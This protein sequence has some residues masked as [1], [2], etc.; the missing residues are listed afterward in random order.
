MALVAALLIAGLTA[1]CA[2]APGDGPERLRLRSGG[3]PRQAL[4]LPARSPGPAPVVLAFHGLGDSGEGFRWGLG[5][6]PALSGATVVLPDALPCFDTGGAP[7]WPAEAGA[8]NLATELAFVE[9]LVHRVAQRFPVDRDRVYALGYSNGA[10]WTVRLVLSRPDLVRGAIVVAGFDPTRAFARDRNGFL[11]LP[12][13]PVGPSGAEAPADRPPL[14]L[15]HGGVDEVVP[16]R[17]GREL[18]ERLRALGWDE[19]LLRFESIQGAGHG[20]PRLLDEERLIGDLR[21][22]QGSG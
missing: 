20:D 12:L 8:P 10:G 6:F 15:I 17:L 22:I 18:V 4:V 3:L 5:D 9:D 1:G 7:C 11:A 14:A 21:W 2:G 16:P 19:E 13:T